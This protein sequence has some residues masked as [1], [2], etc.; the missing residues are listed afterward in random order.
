MILPR[1]LINLNDENYVGEDDFEKKK[2]K[3]F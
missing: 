3:D 1:E 2:K